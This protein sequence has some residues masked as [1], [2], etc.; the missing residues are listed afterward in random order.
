MTDENENQNLEDEPDA[1]G[2]DVENDDNEAGAEL[3]V[4]RRRW[5]RLSVHLFLVFLIFISGMI[6]GGAVVLHRMHHRMG[7]V[8]RDRDEIVRRIHHRISRKYHLDEEQSARAKE[9]IGIHIDE[10]ITLRK[11][12]RP[13]LKEQ[14][15]KFENEIAELMDEK[16]REKWRREIRHFGK[17][18]FPR[19]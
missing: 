13:R 17:M 2:S 11:E 10:V 18:M 3:I 14:F 19:F 16:Q 6:T 8:E 7:N 1:N 5:L 15:V 4:P 12:I 9:I